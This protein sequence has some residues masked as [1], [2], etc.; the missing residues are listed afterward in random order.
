MTQEMQLAEINRKL[1]VLL[2]RSEDMEMRVQM[3]EDLKDDLMPVLNEMTMVAIDELQEVSSAFTMED[4]FRLVKKVAMNTRTLEEM[5]DRAMATNEFL[6]DAQPMLNDVTL[7]VVE[8]LEGMQQKGY[9][10]FFAAAGQALDNAFS[11]TKKSDLDAMASNL[12]AVFEG[13]Q[14]FTNAGNNKEGN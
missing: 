9:F 11:N 12:S 3:I 7:S 13:I 10:G 2:E 4:F 1:D 6:T 14:A 8:Q 5:L